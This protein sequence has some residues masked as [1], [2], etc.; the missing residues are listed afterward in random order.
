MCPSCGIVSLE[1]GP[2]QGTDESG[3]FRFESHRF[4]IS[5][6]RHSTIGNQGSQQTRYNGAPINR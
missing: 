1:V 5:P 2:A 3:Y 6:V 4:I